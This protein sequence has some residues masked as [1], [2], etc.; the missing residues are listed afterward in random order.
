MHMYRTLII[1]F[2]E[3][4]NATNPLMHHQCNLREE[5][6]L[7]SR[8]ATKKGRNTIGRA[9]KLDPYQLKLT[10]HRVRN[11]N[12]TFRQRHLLF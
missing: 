2:L 9:R 3:C 6:D 12:L 4:N 11:N 5:N 8:L 10:M 1:Y 7:A